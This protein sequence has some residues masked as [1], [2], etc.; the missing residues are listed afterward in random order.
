MS[1][2]KSFLD[3]RSDTVT[4]PTEEMRDAMRNAWVGDVVLGED[5][6]VLE[7][8]RMG[9]QLFG[10]EACV[11]TVSGTMSNQAAVLS[12]T[13]RGEQIVVHDQSHMYNLEVAG[14]AQIC[15]VQAR[16][17]H[18]ENGRLD[19]D[20]LRANIIS[21]AVQ[22]APTT[23]V[24]MEN[25]F[26]LNRGLVVGKEH[27]DDVCGVAHGYGI[28]VY[29]DGARILNAAAALKMEPDRLCE[30][31]DAVSVCLSKALGCPIGSLLAGTEEMIGRARRMR[32]ML[33]GG[34]RQGGVVAAAGIV[35]L[36]RWRALEAD[37]VKAR[38]LAFGLKRLGLGIDMNQVQ[39]NVIRIDLKPAGLYSDAFCKTLEGFGVKAKPIEPQAVRMICHKDVEEQDIPVALRAVSDCLNSLA[40]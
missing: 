36:S 32:Q 4:A 24:C 12:M 39:T 23:L 40:V 37:H 22:T 31:V 1:D 30:S 9:A 38:N 8:E 18:A 26:H 21:A 7:L 17:I 10:K 2:K 34:W 28:P 25:T 29:M 6:T 35:G 13:G 27:I 3:L 20:E 33:G 15:G 16:P 19:L 5:P 14:L 11:L